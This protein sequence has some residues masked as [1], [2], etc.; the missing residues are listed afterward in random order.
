LIHAEIPDQFLA[1]WFVKSLLPPIA[2]DVAMSGAV[3]EEQVILR[4]QQLDLIYSQSGTLYDIIP[5]AHRP[6]Y[7][8]QRPTPGPHAD[9]II[10]TV[11]TP[12]I[13]HVTDQMGKLS[14]N[15]ATAV[16]QPVASPS[17]P[18]QTSQVNTVQQAQPGN[19]T[20]QGGRKRNNRRKKNGAGQGTNPQ[21]TNA[22]A[23]EESGKKNK[24]RYP[25]TAC[26][27]DHP[28]H[29]C[30]YMGDIHQFLAQRGVQA[31]TA[32]LT[33]PFPQSQQQLVA[34]PP[35]PPQG[36][37]HAQTSTGGTSSSSSVFLC[38]QGIHIQTRA[39]NYDA[40]KSPATDDS[41]FTQPDG[42]LHIEKPPLEPIPRLPK[43][44]VKKYNLLARAA[45]QYNIVEDLAQSPCA[46][47]SLEVL[48][49][50]P[51]QKKALLSAIGGVYLADPSTIVFNLDQATPRLPAQVAFQIHI[52]SRGT[53]ISRT[54]VDEGACTCVMSASC[55]QALGSPALVP[56]P[57]MLQAFYGHSFQSKGII[58][59]FPIVRRQNSYCG[60][61]GCGFTIGL[62]SLVGT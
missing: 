3:T 40:G 33:N 23:K 45:H 26:K 42:S 2:K 1:D 18:T 50:C 12:S 46:M 10:G 37:S 8:P 32:V 4:A 28:T 31:P 54:V 27:R 9:G 24:N 7:D 61:R 17:V 35:P 25:C 20:H 56:S 62:Q 41:T 59:G 44:F 60:C 47:S 14:V 48:Q 58:V 19:N 6:S 22:P 49:S 36:G 5:H 13:S 16:S 30:P 21:P 38:E 52:K 11:S 34:A 39:K 57:T 53:T 29:Q 15:P 55:W 51:G 43:G